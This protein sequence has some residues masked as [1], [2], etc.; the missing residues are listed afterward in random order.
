[1]SLN[2][3]AASALKRELVRAFPERGE[4][5]A[6]HDRLAEALA[7]PDT[8]AARESRISEGVASLAALKAARKADAST[9]PTHTPGPWQVEGE[10][11]YANRDPRSRHRN[12][13]ACVANI[14]T[15][16]Y[17]ELD[18]EGIANARLIAT[19]PELLEALKALAITL[20][21]MWAEKELTAPKFRQ[22]QLGEAVK[23]ARA[24]IAK[25][26]GGK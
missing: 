4:N 26:E 18:A 10:A 14:C 2:D 1:M 9:K 16:D 6:G 11:V 25:A 13:R 12:G 24:A 20:E 7:K 8:V 23:D 19:A 3:K 17:D 22:C 15:G 5:D 21:E